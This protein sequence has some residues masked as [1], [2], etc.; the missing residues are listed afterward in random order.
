MYKS[1][2][3]EAIS[4]IIDSITSE[5]PTGLKYIYD[6]ASNGHFFQVI[7]ENI[8][9]SESF[10]EYKSNKVFDLLKNGFY[11]GIAFLGPN[12]NTISF[13]QAD[14]FRIKQVQ[15]LDIKIETEHTYKY[16][17]ISGEINWG[18][19]SSQKISIDD[20]FNTI[21]YPLGE[22]TS[23]PSDQ[24]PMDK[25]QEPFNAGNNNHAMAA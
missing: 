13:K 21:K 7:E 25:K 20:V 15:S 4:E 1:N 23:S 16:I 12:D 18:V 24:I 5:F 11:E 9:S 17:T 22:I 10:Q 8:W 3:H 14:T 2:F 6:V 19:K